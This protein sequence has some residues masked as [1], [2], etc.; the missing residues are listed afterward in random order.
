MRTVGQKKGIPKEAHATGHLQGS[1]G[2]DLL[3][4]TAHSG[5][6][7]MTTFATNSRELRGS[8]TVCAAPVA[9]QLAPMGPRVVQVHQAFLLHTL[10]HTLQEY[11]CAG[12]W[13]H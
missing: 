7:S 8:S 5:R 10:H 11:P 3:G 12:Q 13:Q 6:W 1:W 4:R 2:W 9:P